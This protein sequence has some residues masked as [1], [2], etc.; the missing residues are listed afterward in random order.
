MVQGVALRYQAIAEVGIL[1]A[2]HLGHVTCYEGLHSG[3]DEIV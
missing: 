2:C 1:M 3:E